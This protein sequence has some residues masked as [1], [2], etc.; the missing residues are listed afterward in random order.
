MNTFDVILP[1]LR[2]IEHLI[3]DDSISDVMI[4]GSRQVFVERD[5]FLQEV[6][7]VALG[8]GALL[9]AVKNIARYLGDD[10]SESKPILDSRLPDGSRVAAVIPPCSLSGATLTIR[11]FNV[12]QFGTADLILAG[13]LNPTLAKRLEEYVLAR[14]NILISGGAGA[15]KTT[16]LSA[17]MKFIPEDDRIVLI[18]D[19]SEIQISHRNVLRFVAKQSQNGAGSATIRD[20]LEAAMAHRPDRIVV[21]ELHGG[22][23]AFDFLELMNSGH[24][25]AIAGLQA[26]NAQQALARFTTCVLRS[27]VDLPYR[28]LKHNIGESLNVVIHIERS[29]GRRYIDEVLEINNYDADADLFDYFAVYLSQRPR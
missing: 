27:G 28:A 2:P 1:F 26:N 21:G 14:K 13:M 25:G 18:E 7:D 4:N 16:L 24:S 5:G 12:R 29:T 10:I 9:V 22:G 6:P 3:L 8:E 23:E 11:K 20:V 19:R 17:L 15:G